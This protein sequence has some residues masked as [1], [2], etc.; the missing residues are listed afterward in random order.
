MTPGTQFSA[1]HAAA[2]SIPSRL[3]LPPLWDLLAD[4]CLVYTMT[5]YSH[6]EIHFSH[7]RRVSS[8]LDSIKEI[9]LNLYF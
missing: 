9:I 6:P 5:G 2:N 4:G 3:P 1:W 7:I 8:R